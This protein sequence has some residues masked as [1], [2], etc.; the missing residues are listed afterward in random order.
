MTTDETVGTDGYRDQYGV[1]QCLPCRQMLL[2]GH[3]A[4][5]VPV[6]SGHCGE[7]HTTFAI[8]APH[9]GLCHQTFHDDTAYR[10]HRPNTDLGTLCLDGDTAGLVR[11]DSGRWGRPTRQEL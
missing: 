9:C 11:S 2:Y 3:Y 6:G 10:S 1:I 8:A 7:C 5:A 4:D